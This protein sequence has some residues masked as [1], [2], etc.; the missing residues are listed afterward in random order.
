MRSFAARPT[1][2]VLTVALSVVALVAIGPAFGEDPRPITLETFTAPDEGA[3]TPEF[4]LEGSIDVPDGAIVSITMTLDEASAAVVRAPVSRKRFSIVL[5]PE[6]KVL[7]GP[8]TAKAHFDRRIQKTKILKELDK[9]VTFEPS[10]KTLMVGTEEEA[11]AERDK[12]RKRY[13]DILGNLHEVHSALLQRGAY[14]NESAKWIRLESSARD[15]AKALREGRKPDGSM[16]PGELPYGKVDD[17]VTQWER[18]DDEFWGN[19]YE[20]IKFDD[21]EFRGYLFATY[22]PDVHAEFDHLYMLMER[23]Y[24]FFG[25]EIYTR[26][27][28][29]VPAKFQ[30]NESFKF[31]KLYEESLSHAQRAYVLLDEEPIEWRMIDL[32]KPERKED[33]HGDLFR[34]TMSKFEIQKQ[35]SKWVFD[36]HI[37]SP[38]L[39]LRIRPPEKEKRQLAALGVEIHDYPTAEDYKDLGKIHEVA[40]L[41]RWVG[42]RQISKKRIR[43][44]DDTMP[45]GVR[46]GLDQ[47]FTTE[48]EGKTYRVRDYALFCR[49]HKRTYNF[50][51]VVAEDQW[52]TY[53]EDVQKTAESFK[54]LDDPKLKKILPPTEG[55]VEPEDGGGEKKDDGEKKD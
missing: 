23:M 7:P 55:V 26:L 29:K 10:S 21:K 33:A 30:Y 6:G 49:W 46:P 24:M 1:I 17:V 3:G 18:F 38:G 47:I 5:K 25:R 4:V 40:T 53:E 15:M 45:G 44:A 36:F 12:V 16:E 20:T 54:V 34:S 50:I 32:Q 52:T 14:L 11:K 35:G 19:V 43:P 31:S 28:K 13:L 9:D 8:Y 51:S 42:F 27:D 41:G 48:H 37:S 2:P 22:F 39:R